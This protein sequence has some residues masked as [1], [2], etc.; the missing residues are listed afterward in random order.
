MSFTRNTLLASIFAVGTLAVVAHDAQ[1][2][3]PGR[4]GGYSRSYSSQS[5][6]RTGYN[7]YSTPGYRS[8]SQPTYNSY[9]QPVQVIRQVQPAQIQSQQFV[10][11]QAPVQQI[12]QTQQVGPQQQQFAQQ[13]Q[14]QAAPQQQQVAQQPVRQA[15]PQQSPQV[16]PQ[17]QIAPRQTQQVA[18]QSQN[19][20]A[21]MSALQAL[22]GFAPPQA[23]GPQPQQQQIQTPS[24]VGN[25]TASVGNGS[26]VQLSL[27]ADGSFN[28]VATSQ[29]GGTSSF[30]GSY[31]VGNGSLTLNRSNDN[32]QL[33]GNM[34][35]SGN[36]SFSFKVAGNNAA[37]I[38]F[39]RS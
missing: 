31:T 30:S 1:A 22:G 3:P 33:G 9:A 17:Q 18:P 23:S 2:C 26:K 39:N 32:Q 25:W 36:N 21:A 11:Q 35:I 13:P 19:A 20:P 10:Q 24:H 7:N 37:S 34:T 38:N 5:Y 27:L 28:W 14:Q 12:S 4:S 8:Y 6:G 29:S 15:S 16:A